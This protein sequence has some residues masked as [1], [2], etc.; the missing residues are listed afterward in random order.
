MAAYP[1]TE[2]IARFVA[3]TTLDSVPPAAVAVAVAVAK[4]A[5]TD[6]LSVALAGSQDDAG[7]I[8]A[9]VVR[10]EGPREEASVLGHGFRASR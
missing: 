4:I 6:S 8:A 3:E 10:E 9:R 5:I 7:T 2:R 1:A